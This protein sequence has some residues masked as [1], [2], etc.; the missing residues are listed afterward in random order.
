MLRLF[1]YYYIVD[2]ATLAGVKKLMSI[3]F[4]ASYSPFDVSRFQQTP[5]LPH[6]FAKPFVR[7]IS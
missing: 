5:T 3:A 7:S 1:S 4:T 2:V 6:S